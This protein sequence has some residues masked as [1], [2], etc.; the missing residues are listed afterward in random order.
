MRGPETVGNGD[1]EGGGVDAEDVGAR[2][3]S[4]HDALRLRLTEIE[5]LAG[6]FEAGE[7]AV[8]TILREE[9]E[10]LYEAFAAHL[11]LEDHLLVAALA[12]LPDARGRRLATRL[13]REHEEQRELLSFLLERLRE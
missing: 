6:R 2:I 4:D 9:G 5:R 12:A 11:R 3:R 7:E 1:R 10:A 13:A 8:G